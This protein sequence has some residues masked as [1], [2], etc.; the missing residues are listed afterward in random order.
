[1]RNRQGSGLLITCEL[2]VLG[3]VIVLTGLRVT[4]RIMHPEKTEI[5]NT[6]TENPKAETNDSDTTN[7]VATQETPKADTN[8][9]NNSDITISDGAS[10]AVS[11]MSTEDKVAQLFFI[12]P[13]QLTHVGQVV[14]S[15]ESTRKSVN[16]YPVGGLL[17][18]AKNIQ[19]ADQ[20][21][22]MF[23]NM[24]QIMHE[25]MGADVFVAYQLGEGESADQDQLREEGINTTLKTDNNIDYSLTFLQ[26][27]TSLKAKN[28]KNGVEAVKA[29]TEGND[30]LFLPEDFEGTYQAVL[31]GVQSGEITQDVLDNTVGRI[32]TVKGI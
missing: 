5:S 12:T 23:Y 32:L 7:Q 6:K 16:Q 29:I 8:T 14:A 25:K 1:M 4:G 13:E 11:S 15:G 30:M 10:S 19:N 3:L 17:Y 21:K 22:I 24:Q 18:A 27:T 28:V 9:A 31:E 26:G 20:A 2:I